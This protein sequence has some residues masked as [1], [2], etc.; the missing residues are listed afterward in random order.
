MLFFDEAD[1]LFG[2]R[3]EV[4]DAH[5]RYAN[6]EIAYLLQK[7]EQFDGLAILATNLKQNLDEA[8]ARRLTFTVN[9]PFPG[10]ARAPPALGDAVA[11]AGAARRRTSTST[12]SRASSASPAAT[13]ATP[14]SLP[15]I[16]PR[17][18][19][20]S[21]RAAH[22]LHATRREFQKLGKS[23]AEPALSA[24]GL[25]EQRHFCAESRSTAASAS[26]R[27]PMRCRRLSN[28]ADAGR[29]MAML[30]TSAGHQA[31]RRLLGRGAPL[32]DDVRAE[33]ESRF[34]TSFADVRVHA[35]PAAH[36]L[37]S[38][39]DAKAL[40]C[41]SDVVFG[42][43]RFAPASGEGRRLLAH[44]LAHVVQQRRG[45]A[46]PQLEGGAFEESLEVGAD[47][48]ADAAVSTSG[49]I[50]VAGA[51]A[52]GVA[53]SPISPERSGADTERPAEQ[54]VALAGGVV[55]WRQWLAQIESM[56]FDAEAGQ[57]TITIDGQRYALHEAQYRRNLNEA[58]NVVGDRIAKLRQGAETADRIDK[59]IRQIDQNGSLADLSITWAIKRYYGIRA[60]G[61][62]LTDAVRDA[63]AYAFQAAK[64][65]QDGD[66][67][68]AFEFVEAGRVPA[69][70]AARLATDYYDGVMA[71]TQSMQDTLVGSWAD[72]L[73][74]LLGVLK[75]I[76][77]QATD[78]ADTAFWATDE[79]RNLSGGSTAGL[80]T[81]TMLAGPMGAAMTPVVSGLAT[82]HDTLKSMGVVDPSGR[83][84]T[85]GAF[86]TS[87][88]GASKEVT[89]TLGSTFAPDAVLGP[90]DIGDL[91][92]SLGVQALLASSGVKEVTFAADLVGAAA[93]LR[94]VV[95]TYRDKP[96]WLSDT[97]FWSGAIGVALSLGGLGHWSGTSKL[98]NYA[99]KSGQVATLVP[100]IVQFSRDLANAEGLDQAEQNRRLGEDFKR[101]AQ[102]VFGVLQ[103]SRAQHGQ[104]GPEGA[105]PP[106]GP[107]GEGAA[108]PAAILGEPVPAAIGE[109]VPAA[110]PELTA[111]G[112]GTPLP[113]APAPSEAARAPRRQ[114]LPFELRPGRQAPSDPTQGYGELHQLPS[115]E[116]SAPR[117]PDEPQAPADAQRA[118]VSVEEEVPMQMAVG[119]TSG[120]S[121]GGGVSGPSLVYDADAI[122]AS[123]GSGDGDRPRSVP[124][125]TPS[126]GQKSRRSSPGPDTPGRASRPIS[127]HGP[128]ER[129]N[130]QEG[131]AADREAPVE[132][133]VPVDPRPPEVIKTVRTR[134]QPSSE[135]PSYGD[136]TSI[137]APRRGEGRT[138]AQVADVR[139][140]MEPAPRT[141]AEEE[142]IGES[143]Q[144]APTPDQQQAGAEASPPSD[145]PPDWEDP[146]WLQN[147]PRPWEQRK[148]EDVAAVQQRMRAA[149]EVHR[150]A[151]T[152][153]QPPAAPPDRTKIMGDDDWQELAANEEEAYW[154]RWEKGTG[155]SDPAHRNERASKLAERTEFEWPTDLVDPLYAPPQRR[156]P[157]E[158]SPLEAVE[159]ID[160]S[161]DDPA[162]LMG[163][164][165]RPV[166]PDDEPTVARELEPI[167][168]P[169]DEPTVV[170]DD[171]P[172]V[173]LADEPTVDLAD[174]PTVIMEGGPRYLAD[175]LTLN[176]SEPTLALEDAPTAELTD[177]TLSFADAT[178]VVTTRP[179]IPVAGV[180]TVEP[181]QSASSG[182]PPVP[183]PASS[184]GPTEAK[185]KT[186][187]QAVP[188]DEYERTRRLKRRRRRDNR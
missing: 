138:P 77:S 23:I 16:W 26:I 4:K 65:Q 12:G 169:D 74:L 36:A 63:R 87:M 159:D 78:M 52:P 141:Q 66:F 166:D 42:S 145:R 6:I 176:T 152:A 154:D 35:D 81:V 64:A 41:A 37:A 68:S 162:E 98:V 186:G 57:W 38:A 125:P 9:F 127:G 3:S 61:D 17:P 24:K 71:A 108:T 174:E 173:D 50:D 160:L 158:P 185:P 175:D 124:P 22:L 97:N 135:Q 156:P 82:T 184:S 58:N 14:C 51:S 99:L 56:R 171:E 43:G 79:L 121:P 112:A 67:L 134:M 73:Q 187:S 110:R 178:T 150:E 106:G 28:A 149:S 148:P 70:R 155:R 132:P 129:P 45:G 130:P 136:P 72:L 170:S 104:G 180:P 139:A 107:P 62:E 151:E 103:S 153:E 144:E 161:D 13:S 85:T 19:G 113:N 83:V 93:S 119:Q 1:A 120:P 131:G 11:A 21:S 32:P 182:A 126:E 44:E 31:V 80:L 101:F 142:V 10:A 167:V 2:K 90:F 100:P 140:A 94:T 39:V 183:T 34:G 146:N 59:G 75:A 105:P 18:T 179:A 92:G 164:R 49:S 163:D 137:G 84:S 91:G 86:S 54:E 40:A 122:M 27:A 95:N 33:M 55:G 181:T 7:M 46:I 128:G 5:D 8:F 115:P 116:A 30:Q 177:P 88:E 109:P 111:P 47:Q 123:T 20:R 172:T 76:G 117:A 168:E 25:R 48:A 114:V 60:P 133:D 102:T 29:S 69:E 143:S 188:P 89:Q 165:R 147:V 53:L 157:E 118:P 96:D 15:R